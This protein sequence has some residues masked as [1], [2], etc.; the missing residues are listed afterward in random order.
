MIV[1]PQ[2]QRARILIEQQRYPEAERELRAY[3]AASSDDTFAL[4][5][6]AVCLAG[7]RQ[8]ADAQEIL[9]RALALEPDNDALLFHYA[10]VLIEQD[11]W[12]EGEQFLRQAIARNPND[13]DY[14][15]TLA[16]I[17]LHRKNYQQALDEAEL[18]LALDPDNL[19]CLNMRSTALIKLNRKE[20]AFETVDKALDR[21]PENEFT[22][23]NYGW[24]LL[25]KNRHKEALTHFRE[26]LR[27]NPMF[28]PARAGMVEALKSRYLAYRLFLRYAFWVSNMKS[29]FQIMLIVGLYL[30]VQV[31]NYLSD[32]NPTLGMIALPVIVLYVLFALSTWIIAPLSDLVL[33]LNPYGRFALNKIQIRTSNFTAASAA[34]TL[35]GGV[36]AVASWLLAAPVWGF[37]SLTVLGLTLMVPFSSFLKLRDRT[38]SII[39]ILYT[40]AMTLL[41]LAAVVVSFAKNDSEHLLT[42]YYLYGFIGYQVLATFLFVRKNR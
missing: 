16:S 3:L 19:Y 37:V 7:Q 14:R 9:Q 11:Q 23:S 29:Q 20:E 35:I 4:M 13:S 24:G 36:G 5:L 15:A 8:Y 32:Q 30:G 17:C 39:L 25:E 41:G 28:E 40:A 21:D 38:G 42:L 22:H 6:L 2:I 27:I 18:G 31:L 1:D 10:R 34:I 33:R 12:D 26:A